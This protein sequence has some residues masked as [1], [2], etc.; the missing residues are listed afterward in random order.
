M[1]NNPDLTNPKLANLMKRLNA[2]DYKEFIDQLYKDLDAVFIK[3]MDNRQFSLKKWHNIASEDQGYKIW[4][5]DINNQ[6]VTNL[7]FLGYTATHDTY[8]NGH[9]DIHVTSDCSKFRW[10]GE[11]KI[12][13]GKNYISGG[14][15]QLTEKYSTGEKNESCGGLI[16]YSVNSNKNSKTLLKE[17]HDD[18]QSKGICTEM[19]WPDESINEFYSSHVHHISGQDYK[20]KHMII[21]F[22]I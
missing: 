15:K 4:E 2:S 10:Y 12:W 8:A 22:K 6:I 3:L 14:W 20:V 17:W 11:S 13:N 1:L 5:D 21:N 16:I 9:V 18:L 7:Y 19:D